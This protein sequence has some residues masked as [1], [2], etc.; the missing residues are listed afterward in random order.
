MIHNSP[1][2]VLV[3]EDDSLLRLIAVELIEDAGF[4][5]VEAS[6]ADQAIAALERRTDITLLFTDVD[7]P[8]SID[9]L[10]LAHS[11]RSRW[12]AINIIIVSS[13]THLTDADLPSGSRFFSKPYST[14]HMIKLLHL[15]YP[16]LTD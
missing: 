14:G 4:G 5:V 9:G 2:V 15:F 11:V 8:G 1:P 7:M 12:P 16:P 13:K 10:R 6:N 3:V